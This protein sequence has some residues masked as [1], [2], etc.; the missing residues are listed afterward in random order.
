MGV[1]MYRPISYHD[2]KTYVE[3][4]LLIQKTCICCN[5]PFTPEN[6]KTSLGWRETQISGYCEDC[7]DKIFECDE[8]TVDD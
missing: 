1:S 4:G 2:F 5:E 3:A 7:W 6:V 8:E